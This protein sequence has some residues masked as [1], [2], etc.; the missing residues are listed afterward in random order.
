MKLSNVDIEPDEI[1]TLNSPDNFKKEITTDDAR[2]STDMPIVIKYD[3]ID[4]GKT[5]Y[6]FRQPFRLRDTQTY[7]KMMKTISSNTINTLS[8][9]ARKYHFYRTPIVGK[10]EEIMKRV[11]PDAVKTNQIVFHFALYTNKNKADRISD[12]RSPRIYF[13]LGT[14]GFIYPIFFDP[15]HEIQQMK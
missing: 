5:K 9:N 1:K 8:D 13:I 2:I 10:L 11:I 6:S 12:T 3:Y 14:N 4:L 15:F 7:F